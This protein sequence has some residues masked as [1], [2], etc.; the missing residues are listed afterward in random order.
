MFRSATVAGMAFALIVSGQAMAAETGKVTLSAKGEVSLARGGKIAPVAGAATL[1]AGDRVIANDGQ[2]QLTYADGCVVT[3]RPQA[4]ATIAAKSPCAG[5]EGLVSAGAASAQL[6][7]MQW[8]GVG[9]TVVVL[10][11]GLAAAFDD[12][13]PVSN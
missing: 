12:D 13:D 8:V 3:L 11:F 2:A 1:Q 10:G 4:M 5:A 6:T 9:L 7:T